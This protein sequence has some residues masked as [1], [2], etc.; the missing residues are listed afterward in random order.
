MN[1]PTVIDRS[2]ITRISS[3]T[4]PWET[5]VRP[6]QEG[7]RPLYID[8]HDKSIVMYSANASWTE[9]YCLGSLTNT[10]G[11]F[12][13][14]ASWKKSD[15]PLFQ[16]TTAV[17]GPGG[18]SYVKSPDGTEDWIVYHAQKYQGSGWDRNIRTQKFTFYE[19]HNPY[20]GEPVQEGVPI[21]KP[22]GE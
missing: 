6:I 19:N 10:D 3:P 7:Q 14:P 15:Q 4:E 18:A 22:S 21:L 8:K 11:D 5:S 17:F 13:N 9:D 2:T 1:D 16:K 20:F 12:L